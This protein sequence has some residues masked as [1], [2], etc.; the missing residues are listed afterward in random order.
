MKTL[1]EIIYTYFWPLVIL[2]EASIS[3]MA[4]RRHLTSSVG[5]STKEEKMDATEPAEAF[6]TSLRRTTTPTVWQLTP[7]QTLQQERR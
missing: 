6:C 2:P 7:G 4:C 5:H 3:Y 1:N